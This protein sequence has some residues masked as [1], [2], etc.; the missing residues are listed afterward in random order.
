[1]VRVKLL[2]EGKVVEVDLQE[3]DTVRDL[4]RALGLSSETHVVLVGGT[5]V[6]E[7]EKIGAGEVVVVRVL[8]G[9]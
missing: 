4:L 2:P 8:S 5:P 7:T 9:G 6:P 3:G 1:M